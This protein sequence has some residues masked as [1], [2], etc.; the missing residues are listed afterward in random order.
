MNILESSEVVLEMIRN[1]KAKQKI[2]EV[3]RISSNG[4]KIIIYQ[5]NAGKGKKQICLLI[6]CH[7][8][9]RCDFKL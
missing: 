9:S 7:L 5:P 2:I 4:D 6:S 1:K 8:N 3:I